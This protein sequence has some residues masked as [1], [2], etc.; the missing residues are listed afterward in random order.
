MTGE[1]RPVVE[2]SGPRWLVP[3]LVAGLLALTAVVYVPS[4]SD[5]FVY[6][7]HRFIP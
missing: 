5:S 7:D 3:S 1:E 4:L 2:R 6:D